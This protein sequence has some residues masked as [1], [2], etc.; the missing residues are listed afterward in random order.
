[1]ETTLKEAKSILT[2]QRKGFLAGGPYPFTHALSAY[3]GCGFGRTTCGMYCYAQFLPNWSFGSNGAAW[4][5]AVQ[6]KTNAATLLE[7]ELKRMSPEARGHLRIFMS[8]TTDPYQPLERTYEVTRQCLEVFVGFPDLDLLVIQTRSPLAER[9]L[10]L[11]TRIPYAWLSVTIETDDQE[12]LKQL[13][14][15]PALEKRWELVRAAS[16][17]GVPTQITVSPCL[18]YSSVEQFGERLLTSGARRVIVDTVVDGDGSGGRRTAHSPFAQAESNWS[19]TS[20]AHHLYAYLSE[21]AG[22]HEIALGW[23]NAGFC[24]IAPTYL[25]WDAKI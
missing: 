20:A 14:G 16:Q 22:E 18:P 9:D 10:P 2:P 21:R 8:S 7:R 15:G 19:E 4:G 25:I 5:D 11:L 13:R 24:G 17:H 12:Y 23:S 1:M 3:V 6:V